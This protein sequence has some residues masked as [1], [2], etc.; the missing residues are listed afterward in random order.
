MI[1]LIMSEAYWEIEA[2]QDTEVLQNS[3]S[4]LSMVFL[5]Q[6]FAQPKNISFVT[7]LI[8]SFICD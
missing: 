1:G 2:G 6:A 8:S 4:P 3:I 5:E 7:D